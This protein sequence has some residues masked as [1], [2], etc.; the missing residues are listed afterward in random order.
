[1]VYGVCGICI[2]KNKISDNQ[3]RLGWSM[4]TP[5]KGVLT[6][7]GVDKGVSFSSNNFNFHMFNNKDLKIIKKD[8]FSTNGKEIQLKIIGESDGTVE[9]QE[10]TIIH[11]QDEEK[12][13]N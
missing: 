5:V 13:N 1:M 3:S 2:K 8:G 11:E 7:F 4:T 12:E 9:H 6:D 10:I